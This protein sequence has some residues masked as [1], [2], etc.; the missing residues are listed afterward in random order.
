MRYGLF[1][2]SIVMFSTNA[3]AGAS[4]ST[5]TSNSEGDKLTI[6]TNRSGTV[7]TIFNKQ[8]QVVCTRTNGETNHAKAV[9]KYKN[10]T[11]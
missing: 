1:L 8:G 7:I 3:F 6:L 4:A 9:S 5:T 11:C 10:K 2:L